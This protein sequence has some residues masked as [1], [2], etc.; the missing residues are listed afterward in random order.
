M[1][2]LAVAL[3]FGLYLDLMLLFGTSAFALYALRGAERASG[4]VLPLL[5]VTLVTA[6]AALPLSALGLL[7]LTASMA[8]TSLFTVDR[9]TLGVVLWGTAIGTAWIVRMTALATAAI[10]AIALRRAPLAASLVA[11]GGGAL[12]LATLAWS[13]HG[14]MQEG[15]S[16]WLHLGSDIAHLLAAALW[17]GALFCLAALLFARS[18]QISAAQ[19]RL[20]HRALADFSTAGTLAVGVLVATGLANAFW[21]LGWEGLAGLPGT[22]YGQLLIVKLLLFAAMLG[23]AAHNRFRLVPRLEAAL[24]ETPSTVLAALRRSVG[25]ETLIG[26][27][28]LALV[29]WFGTLDP[30]AAA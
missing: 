3:R 28:V 6:L 21:I 1:D 4:A 23:F 20:T 17:I 24:S 10:A 5:P 27:T 13:G 9:D 22:R 8:G 26:T 15:P 7:A 12:A 2:V 18:T 14:A 11:T 30:T 19:L 25:I 29:A 16:G